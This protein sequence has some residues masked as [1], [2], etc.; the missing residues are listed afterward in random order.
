[1]TNTKKNAEATLSPAFKDTI[2]SIRKALASASKK[3]LMSKYEVG[4]KVEEVRTR[5]ADEKYG[6]R[7]VE[8]IAKAVRLTA[9][10]LYQFADV[11][12]TWTPEQ[13][14]DVSSRAAAKGLGFSH[15][16][17]LAHKDHAAHRDELVEEAIKERL[18]LSELRARRGARATKPTDILE[19]LATEG[20]TDELRNAIEAEV[21]K[22]HRR[23]EEL[24][25]R[26]E[27]LEAARSAWS[28]PASSAEDVSSQLG[29]A[30]E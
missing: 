12:R 4:A 22:L 18:K 13:F 2:E 21:H 7:A 19:R 6:E 20:P 23:H 17:E 11:S 5:D 15:F 29:K 26:L 9:S 10:R 24:A 3:D 28:K 14:A 16:H 27:D 1:M 25:R 30:A 8:T